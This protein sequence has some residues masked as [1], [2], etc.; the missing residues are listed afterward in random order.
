M[1]GAGRLSLHTH[2]QSSLHGYLSLGGAHGDKRQLTRPATLSLGDSDNT[3][4]ATHPRQVFFFF[5][6]VRLDD[7]II[8]P[9]KNRYTQDCKMVI[10]TLCWRRVPRMTRPCPRGCGQGAGTVVCGALGVIK[11]QTTGR[12]SLWCLCWRPLR[13]I[14][15]TFNY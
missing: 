8:C 15:L 1:G 7:E 5:S 14:G 3:T 10:C 12:L 13:G 9:S 11:S 6:S 2:S 4:T